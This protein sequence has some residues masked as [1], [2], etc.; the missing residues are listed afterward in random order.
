MQSCAQGVSDARLPNSYE[1]KTLFP[2]LDLKAQF[3]SIRED[4]LS[5]VTRV[6]ESQQLIMGPE[7]AALENEIAAF[8]GC[9]FAI[10][11][12]SGSDALLLALTA[13]GIGAGNSCPMHRTLLA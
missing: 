8:I 9:K 11:C 5:A 2:F 4:I 7:V 13:C 6:L 12:A 1:A 3:A 10:A